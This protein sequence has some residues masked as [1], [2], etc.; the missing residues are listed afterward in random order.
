M[1]KIFSSLNKIGVKLGIWIGYCTS[2]DGDW[3]Y[4][5]KWLKKP[6]MEVINTL[7]SSAFN[8]ITKLV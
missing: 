3:R 5:R 1:C 8:S 4:F 2:E 6:N 7:D